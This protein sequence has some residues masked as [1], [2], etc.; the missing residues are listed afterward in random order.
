MN[1]K[2][3]AFICPLSKEGSPTRERSDDI[4]NNVLQPIARKYGY[5]IQRAD[6]LT[7]R[8]IMQDI[9]IMLRDADI[10]IADLTD[11][12]PNVFYELGL[13]QATKGKCINIICDEVEKVPF[14]LSHYRVHEYRREGTNRD[15]YAFSQF[16]EQNIQRMQRIPPDPIMQLQ[17]K[18]ISQAYNLSLVTDFLK[19]PKNHYSLAKKMFAHRCRRI[20]LMQRSSSLVLNAEQ[21]WGEEAEFI[22]K[23]RKAINTCD[24][25]YHI[26]SL[27]GIEG[28][29]RR[30]NSIFPSFKD[31]TDNLVNE[32][33]KVALQKKESKNKNIFYIRKL[34]KDNENT[35]F[36]L[37][38]Q[39][40]VLATEDIYGNVRAVLVQ[41][42]GIDQTSFMIEGPKARD[43]LDVC[44]DFY[45]TCELVDWNELVALYE[46][47]ESIER[48]RE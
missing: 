13:R 26:I 14:D 7:G 38:R 12:N 25:C 10:V 40:R 37:D 46:T 17:P 42:L 11:L 20:F 39:S 8:S 28:H 47:Y 3:I 36:K 32:G 2:F 43:Y 21:G 24:F 5:A 34:P 33:G 1:K 27:D 35:L 18:D 19:G 44:V 22:A 9:I 31:Y 15:F 16:I 29:F 23:M 6:K 48:E 41:N 45:N 30:K 4:M